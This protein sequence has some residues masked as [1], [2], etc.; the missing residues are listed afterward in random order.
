[1]TLSEPEIA[2]SPSPLSSAQ[3][4]L[5]LIEIL[6]EAGRP[7]GVSELA[8]RVGAVR[9]TIHKQL[10]G[11]VGSEWVEQDPEGRY[12]LTLKAARIGNAAL[13][14]AGL[15]RRIHALL[16]QVASRARETVSIAA[17][18]DDA[19]VIVQRAES[20]HV[21]HADIRVGTRVGL[22]GGASGLVLAAFALSAEDR[23]ELRR[24][25]VA[26]ASEDALG[27]VTADG[28]AL[29]VGQLAPGI[30]AISVPL[31]DALRFQTVALT[32]SGPSDRLDPVSAEG[33]LREGRDLIIREI[34]G[35]PRSA[36]R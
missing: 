31:Y 17:L 36:E 2:T 11:L 29:T 34:S 6:A 32:I 20:G 1:M 30:S 24:R 25:G 22:D 18:A 16:E 9:G 4:T 33:F 13:E 35:T 7:L 10:A 5:R 3:K 8:R 26:V 28:L 19:A 23:E 15:G 27:T 14:Q 21:L 12:R